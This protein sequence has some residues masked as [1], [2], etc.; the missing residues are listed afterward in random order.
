VRLARDERH[1]WIPEVLFLLTGAAAATAVFTWTDLDR[2][3]S[4]VFYHPQADGGPWPAAARLPWSVLHRVTPWLAAGL[5]FLGLGLIVRGMLVAGRRDLRLDG[6][7]IVLSLALGPGLVVNAVF[8]DN[9]KRP[10]PR[11]TITLG[12]DHAYVPPF[13]I[14]PAGKSFPCGH[15]SVGFAYGALYYALRRRRPGAARTWLAASALAG[16]VMGLGRVA[17][18]GHFASD[19]VFAAILTYGTVAGVYYTLLGIPRRKEAPAGAPAIPT[20]VASPPSR[21]ARFPRILRVGLVAAAG[22]LLVFLVLLATPFEQ[23]LG[24]S[25]DPAIAS[26]E[27][28]S[29]VVRVGVGH[30]RLVLV[31]EGALMTSGGAY[32]GFGFPGGRILESLAT[33]AQ[34]RRVVYAVEARGWFTDLEGQTVVKVK[35]PLVAAVEVEVTDGILTIE[36]RIGD[37]PPP[38]LSCRIRPDALRLRGGVRRDQVRIL[39][40]G[41]LSPD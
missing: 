27:P 10:R 32:D 6:L 22:V 36:S 20:A 28:W 31:P 7:L 33:D 8:K 29:L 41:D 39:A 30:A 24:R 40:R 35:S 4:R 1:R 19:V 11:Q 16:T 23:P 13:R 25:F 5:G 15:C 9:W 38:E 37:S 3:V 34:A 2:E 17:S 21:P 12:G 26:G 18:G 14:G